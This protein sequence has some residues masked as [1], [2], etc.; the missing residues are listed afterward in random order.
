MSDHQHPIWQLL[1]KLQMDNRAQAAKLVELR[2]LVASLELPDG[3]GRVK[4]PL[5]GISF[6]SDRQIA[7]HVYNSHAGPVPEHYLAA[8]RLAGET[9]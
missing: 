1:D 4:C 2:A 7:E 5:C 3:D 9:A 8:E 6:R